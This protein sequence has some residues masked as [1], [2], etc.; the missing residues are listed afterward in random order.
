MT[1]EK[2][3][4]RRLAEL[5]GVYSHEFGAHSHEY[6][7]DGDGTIDW[8]CSK[9]GKY[10]TDESPKTD[11]GTSY[12]AIAEAE[13]MLSQDEQMGY[14]DKFEHWYKYAYDNIISAVSPEM[15]RNA[16]IDVLKKTRG[17]ERIKEHL[18]AR[19]RQ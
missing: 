10:V 3:S 15:R 17:K 5:L 19:E 16:M 14:N 12:D 1:S 18:E 7:V 6:R 2:Y 8:V 13:R 4:D 9:C 11:Y